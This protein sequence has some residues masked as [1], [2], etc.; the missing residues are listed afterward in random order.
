MIDNKSFSELLHNSTDKKGLSRLRLAK[1]PNR[2]KE[3]FDKNCNIYLANKNATSTFEMK[4][5][6]KLYAQVSQKA[7][8]RGI[9]LSEYMATLISHDINS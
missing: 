9:A 4:L 1:Q 6:S 2:F 7:K 5:N 8:D 3:R